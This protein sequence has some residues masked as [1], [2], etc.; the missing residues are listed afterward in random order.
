MHINERLSQNLFGAGLLIFLG[1]LILPLA[2]N[3]LAILFILATILAGF[4]IITEGFGETWQDTRMHHKFM[5]NIHLLMT[6]AAFGAILIGN[7]EEA[8]LL[9]LIF[10]AAHILE[11]YAE[12]KSKREITKLLKMNPTEAKRIKPDGTI[13]IVAVNQLKIGDQLQVVN[14]AQI[15]TDGVILSGMTTI[16]EASITGE[17]MPQEKQ[18]GDLVYGS[19]INGPSAFTMEVTKASD[20]TVFAKI[21]ELVKQSQ[22]SLSPAA[23]KIKKIEPYYVTTVLALFPLVIILGPVAFDWSWHTSLYRGLVFLISAS[24]CA[25]AASAIPA[26]LS[27]ISN[28]AK[29]GVLFKGGAYLTNLA[30]LKNIAFDKTGTLTIGKPQVT[31]QVFLPEVDQ[32]RLINIIFAME[33][34]ANHP[35]ATAIVNHYQNVITTP[36][37][38]TVDN[39]IG[40]GLTAE[41]AG[42]HYQITKPSSFPKL[43]DRLAT[44]LDTLSHAGKTVV[45]IAKDNQPIGLLALMDIPN[46]NAKSAIN[47]FKYQNIH[48]T[49]ITGDAK[50]TGEAIGNTLGIDSVLA[51]VLPTQ[52]ADVIKQNQVNGATAMVGDGVNDAPALAN[53][54]I[55]IA[56]GDGTDVAIEVADVVVMQ[57]DLAKLTYAHRISKKLNQ[58]IWQNM[59]FAL[60]IVFLLVILNFMSITNI[61]L[62]IIAHE[63]S[64]LLVI[65]NGLRLLLPLRA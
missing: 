48:T 10:A 20:D 5:P 2:N 23:T 35:L 36:L 58:V 13:E 56:M 1:A 9:I 18:P 41:Y 7:F 50:L 60:L 3:I 45:I 16:D 47:Y 25:L 32:K 8:A 27:G 28:L 24:P 46:E 15:P 59:I 62:G 21:L 29:R 61:T 6:L 57:N 31:D 39:K 65:F 64:T 43:P 22:A 4:E 49:M 54:D 40:H 42:S 63:G 26:T 38:L 53:A 11:E 34:A 51:N 55:G 14:S 37:T 44:N 33:Q 12:N 30:D 17:S 52:K 19:T